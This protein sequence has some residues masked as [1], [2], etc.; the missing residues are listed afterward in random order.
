M[1]DS[2]TPRL[3]GRAG[4]AQRQRRL[5]LY[6]LCV[7]CLDK[8]IVRP[9]EE[10]DHIIRLE[11]GGP[12]TDD[13]CQGLCKDCHKEKTRQENSKSEVVEFGVDGYPIGEG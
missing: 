11:D 9:T 3:R 10:I 1:S 2:A 7:S 5:S 8:G 12:D 13:N 4:V 6:P